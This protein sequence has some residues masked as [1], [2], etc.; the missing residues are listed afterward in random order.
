MGPANNPALSVQGPVSV[1]QANLLHW[2]RISRLTRLVSIWT[3]KT[4]VPAL[5]QKRTYL[6]PAELRVPSLDVQL[7]TAWH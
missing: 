7:P 4:A 6:H 1:L 5:A 3:D 2:L